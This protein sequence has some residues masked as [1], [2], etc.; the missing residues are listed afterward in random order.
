MSETTVIVVKHVIKYVQCRPCT[1]CEKPLTGSRLYVRTS[2]VK[3]GRRPLSFGVGV[4]CSVR[5]LM[6]FARK[7]KKAKMATIRGWTFGET[8]KQA[9]GY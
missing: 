9:K 5:C 6:A 7:K 8:K 1:T 2:T 3:K 4:F